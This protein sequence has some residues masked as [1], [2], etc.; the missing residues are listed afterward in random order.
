MRQAL[1]LTLVVRAVYLARFGW[2]PRWANAVYM[3]QAKSWVVGAPKLWGP[4]LAQLARL[5]GRALGLSAGG[6]LAVAATLAGHRLTDG[7]FALT[8]PTYAYYAFFAGLPPLMCAAPCD[9]EYPAYIESARW[10]GRFADNH[11]SLLLALGRHPG[12]AA[13]RTL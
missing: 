12:A 9:S 5:G 7:R 3:G 11:G 8:A 1:G 10:F 6:A 13:L 4:P 2:D